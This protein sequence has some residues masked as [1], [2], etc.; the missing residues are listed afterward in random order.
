LIVKVALPVLVS[1]EN[2]AALVVPT[3]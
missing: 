1:V 3:V 2:R